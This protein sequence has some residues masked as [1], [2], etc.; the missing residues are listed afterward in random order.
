MTIQHFYNS[1]LSETQYQIKLHEKKRLLKIG[2]SVLK[3]Q[4]HQTIQVTNLLESPNNNNN[5]N[6]KEVPD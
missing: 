4:Q 2:E 6:N 3:Q 5:N 1:R